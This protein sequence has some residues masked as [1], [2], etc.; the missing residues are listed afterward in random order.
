[1][2]P[3]HCVRILTL[4]ATM[5]LLPSAS[6][7]SKTDLETAMSYDGLEKISIKGIDLAYARPGATLAG[8]DRVMLDPV[9]V[10]FHKNWNPTRA[11]SRIK[12]SAED[13]ERIRAG[14]AKIVFDE[15]V[16]ELQTKSSYQVVNEAGPDVLRVK[17]NI[18]NL[19]VNAPDTRTAAS[20]RTY[21]VSA[22]EMTLFAEL[23]DA[24]TG[25]LLAR[26]VD[27]REA[28]TAPTLMLA[29]SVVNAEEA[30]SIASIWARILRDA[31][32]KAHGIGRK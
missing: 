12:L 27:R 24:E 23:Y 15:F 31:M 30:R 7:A 28:R 19:Y 8:Y 4:L 2:K 29:N 3:R 9:D 20:S 14:V 17:V 1:M 22:G 16:K 25:E 11:G 10:A 18:V 32:D 5:L 6:A 26:V 21:V 13:R